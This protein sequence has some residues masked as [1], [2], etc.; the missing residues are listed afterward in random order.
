[1]KKS[2]SIDGIIL[3]KSS[4][5]DAKL[6]GAMK[7]RVYLD[8]GRLTVQLPQKKQ[9]EVAPIPTSKIRKTTEM[10]ISNA[11]LDR[12]IMSSLSSLP[13]ETLRETKSGRKSEKLG[14]KPKNKKRRIIKRIV[15]GLV[16]IGV[17]GLVASMA[18]K[19]FG[20]LGNMF[21]GNPLDILTSNTPLDEDENGRTNILILGTADDEKGHDGGTL[22]DSIMI[23]SID[24]DKYDAYMISIPRDLW[25]KYG[26]AC[27]AG[28][29]GKINAAYSCFGGGTGNVPNDKAALK[30]SIPLFKGVT[31]VEIQYAVNVNYTVFRDVVNAI[32]GN[33]TVNIQ[34]RNSKGILDS[35][36]DWKCGN[37]KAKRVKN[38]PP[39]GHYLQ[40]PNGEQT[41]DA[42]HALYLALARGHDAPTYGLEQSNFDREK[43]QQL[44]MTAIVG[45][46][47]SNGSLTNLSSVMSLLDGMGSNL[48]TTF[49]TGNIKTLARIAQNFDA[50]S[51]KS[52]SLIDAESELL[53]TGMINGQS[54]VMPVTG[55]YDYSK[56]KAYLKINLSNDPVVRENPTIH[57]YNGG[58]ASGSAVTVTAQ[59]TDKGY[60]A[61]TKGNIASVDATYVIYDL[62]DGKKSGS[63]AALKKLFNVNVENKSENELPAG[64]VKGADFVVIIGSQA[65]VESGNN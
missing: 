17:L 49:D 23:L 32:G 1:M 59:L 13:D 26:Q 41:I 50:A 28:Y 27:P 20:N 65:V 3:S 37:T 39:D 40:L 4:A 61:A 63:A 56:I 5:S 11:N 64:V 29:E 60:N 9:P 42:E 36:F 45:K 8:G 43:N 25:V 10:D 2:Q 51:M 24:Q 16:I 12:D 7:R 30:K 19:A 38:C 18:L 58:A 52:I 62:T 54:V 6:D 46:A 48:R 22:T 34:S 21:E 14:K 53:K 31:G 35:T 57:V 55:V 44:V 15:V 47:K 33:I